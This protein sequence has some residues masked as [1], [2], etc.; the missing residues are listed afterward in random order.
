M[1]L[2]LSVALQLAPLFLSAKPIFAI[3]FQFS[4]ALSF[5][6]QLEVKAPFAQSIFV[7]PLHATFAELL[8]NVTPL[9]YVFV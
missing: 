6:V 2:L 1:P 3:L 9:R 4:I 5:H 7:F 8:F